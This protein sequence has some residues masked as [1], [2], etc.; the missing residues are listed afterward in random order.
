MRAS[1]W[2]RHN[3]RRLRRLG[4]GRAQGLVSRAGSDVEFE[5][6]VPVILI[7]VLHA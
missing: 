2:K 7:C 5:K 3:E 6:P 1:E 4:A